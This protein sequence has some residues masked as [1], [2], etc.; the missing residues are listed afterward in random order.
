[1]DGSESAVEIPEANFVDEEENMACLDLA[2]GQEESELTA[3]DNDQQTIAGDTGEVATEPGSVAT[4][5][6]DEEQS[7]GERPN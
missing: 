3:S 2:N 1:M 5:S 4:T 7:F 6:P